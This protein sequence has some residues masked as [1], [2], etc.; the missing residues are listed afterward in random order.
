MPLDGLRMLR[1]C[2][3]AANLPALLRGRHPHLMVADNGKR[4]VKALVTMMD[5][6]AA[7]PKSTCLLPKS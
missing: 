5:R 4:S 3:A 6:D 1:E 7:T 2:K